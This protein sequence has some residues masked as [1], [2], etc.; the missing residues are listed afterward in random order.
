MGGQTRKARHRA[1][2]GASL[3]QHDRGHY[4][5]L[6]LIRRVLSRFARPPVQGVRPGRPRRTRP[7]RHGAARLPADQRRRAARPGPDGAVVCV[8]PGGVP[9]IGN[10]FSRSRG[11]PS[12]QRIDQP[13]YQHGCKEQQR[14]GQCSSPDQRRAPVR[15]PGR[16][17]WSRFA[18]GT[19]GAANCSFFSS[20]GNYFSVGLIW[21]T[22][23][24]AGLSVVFRALIRVSNGSATAS[25]ALI[26]L[27]LSPTS[28]AS[29][30]STT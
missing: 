25:A 29:S 15:V 4:P 18:A 13:V 2:A 10:G 11:V 30:P 6:Q 22:T 21:N 23:A 28:R 1:I 8:G 16:L 5:H 24:R 17:R 12:H 3:H 27:V 7:A 14:R 20:S 9:G 19:S 26:D